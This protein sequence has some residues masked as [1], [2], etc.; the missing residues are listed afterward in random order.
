M[1]AGPVFKR[2]IAASLSADGI[3]ISISSTVSIYQQPSCA[4]AAIFLTDV[5]LLGE[6]WTGD[7]LDNRP[8]YSGRHSH[9]RAS[10][11]R[12]TS[13]VTPAQEFAKL[14][15][16][17][18]KTVCISLSTDDPEDDSAQH[19]CQNQVS[20]KDDGLQQLARR[21]ADYQSQHRAENGG[22]DDVGKSIG[23]MPLLLR[24]RLLQ[25]TPCVVS[26]MTHQNLNSQRFT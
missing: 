26:G 12:R 24:H 15:Q 4:I 17:V 8:E 7:R 3:L 10:I 22:N 14:F 23:V 6:S 1:R 11:R 13:E 9:L 5:D 19:E 2:W 25:L 20:V 16:K 18:F 21:Q